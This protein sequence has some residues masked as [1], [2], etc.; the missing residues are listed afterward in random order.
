VAVNVGKTE[1]TGFP[2][3]SLILIIIEEVETP[4][5]LTGV[6]PR[7]VEVALLGM[8]AVKRTVPSDLTTGVA[9]A[10]V[11]VS[12]LVELKVQVDTPEALDTEHAP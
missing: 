10:S 4:S 1:T 2:K 7:I 8:P 12:A 11:F 9:I 3:T 5:A 6:E